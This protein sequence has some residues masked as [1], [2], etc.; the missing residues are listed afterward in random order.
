VQSKLFQTVQATV[1]RSPRFPRA[2]A[3]VAIPRMQTAHGRGGLLKNATLT[4]PFPP[5]LCLAVCAALV[6]K[7]ADIKINKAASDCLVA[8][9][10]ACTLQFVLSQSTVWRDARP[11][12]FPCTYAGYLACAYCHSVVYAALEGQKNPKVFTEILKWM[13]TTL[14]EFGL[15]GVKS[16]DLIQF[17]KGQL[18]SAAPL[19]RKG[20]INVLVVLRI[21]LGPGTQRVLF[22]EAPASLSSRSDHFSPWLPSIVIGMTDVRSL[23]DDVKPAILSTVQA[24]FD[25]VTGQKPPAPTRFVRSEGGAGG[26]A[27]AGSGASGAT[28]G[29]RAGGGSGDGADELFPRVDLRP[30]VSAKMLSDMNDKNWKLREE[31]LQEVLRVL[32]EVK[33]IQPNAGDVINALKLRLADSNKNLVV[34]ALQILGI[35]ATAMGKPFQK[36]YKTI[37]TPVLKSTCA[38]ARTC[39]QC[40]G[41]DRRGH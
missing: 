4:Q 40:G 28:G 39:S 31:A 41:A 23:L 15:G 24:E 32:E 18:D 3:A 1:Q 29:A 27:S 5:Q 6:E 25:K 2:G 11:P 17:L 20:A 22:C 16:R 35:M 10:E 26:P 30:L 9:A 7:L 36:E 12:C 14:P 37:L 19:V 8:I 38:R 34:L 21:A 13:E 33:R